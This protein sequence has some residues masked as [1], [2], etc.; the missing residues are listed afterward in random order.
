MR[1]TGFA[2]SPAVAL[3][4]AIILGGAGLMI[5]MGRYDAGPQP[6]QTWRR[7]LLGGEQIRLVDDGRYQLQ[8]WSCI[9]Q[10]ETFESG[11][12]AK[13]GDV[14]SL[15]PTSGS[16]KPYLMRMIEKD[17]DMYLMESSATAPDRTSERE[18]FERLD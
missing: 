18:M 10:D 17:G 1:T 9:G 12:W 3:V 15:V 2:I 13:I 7:G 4:L 14:V 8:R 5:V 11:T 6:G 16:R